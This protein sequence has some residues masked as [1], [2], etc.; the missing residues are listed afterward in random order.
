MRHYRAAEDA[1]YPSEFGHDG[2][3]Y[4]WPWDE[5]LRDAPSTG[6]LFWTSSLR[7]YIITN[8]M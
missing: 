1:E 7:T 4:Q 8:K 5:N 6:A 2:E 3:K